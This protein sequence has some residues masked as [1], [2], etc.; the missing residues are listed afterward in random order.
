MLQF[1]HSATYVRTKQ[2]KN[3]EHYLPNCFLTRLFT[4]IINKPLK[5]TIIRETYCGFGQAMDFLKKEKCLLLI[6]C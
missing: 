1:R 4:G 5:S 3:N 6:Y 2:S